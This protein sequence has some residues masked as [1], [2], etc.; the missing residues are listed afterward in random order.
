MSRF[1]TE[2]G[3][4]IA[5]AVVLGATA[6]FD[7]SYRDK[8]GYNAQLLLRQASVLGIFALGAGVVI[9]SGG[10][11]LSSGAMIAYSATVCGCVMVL[12]SPLDKYGNIYP[13]DL[14]I[15]VMVLA[16]VAALLAAILVGSLHAWLITA[17]RL[18]PFVATLA[19]L[20]GLRSLSRMV[21][22]DVYRFA[23]EG[24]QSARL[25]SIFDQNF[26]LLFKLWY[27]PPLTLIVI[28]GLTWFVLSKTIA[29]RHLYAMGGNE[30]AARL[31]GVRTDRLKWLAYGFAAF[32]SAVAGVFLLAES[33]Q[34]EPSSQAMGYELNAIAAAVIGGCIL[35]GGS[36][37]VPGIVLGAL[38]LRCAIDSVAKLAR[39]SV[40]PDVLEGL[41]VGL[42]ILLTVAFN[43][44]RTEGGLKR[45]FFTGMLGNTAILVLTGLA[46]AIAYVLS[47]A[48]KGAIALSTG[49]V[50][51]VVL[52][53]KK[54]VEVRASRRLR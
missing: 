12:L 23:S 35:T 9:I 7:D 3:L 18:P 28:S 42:L 46:M 2:L 49:F 21:I 13:G 29:G 14:P 41:V 43:E 1:R 37:S 27:I 17:V 39:G 51:L 11:D 10:I 26:K 6:M 36:G 24:E 4:L 31:S 38:F 8:P 40:S 15:W 48:N 53:A 34:A 20:I 32:T 5:I 19:S 52:G 47:D 44:L 16:I 50:V 30:E 45:P 33:A 54:V 25:I 22:P